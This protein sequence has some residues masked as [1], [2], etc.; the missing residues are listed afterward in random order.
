MTKKPAQEWVVD[1]SFLTASLH[2]EGAPNETA[3]KEADMKIEL[4]KLMDQV[5]TSMAD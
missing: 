2:R 3:D 1:A 4:E 5:M